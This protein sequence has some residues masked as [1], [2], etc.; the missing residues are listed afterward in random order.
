MAE[1]REK[2]DARRPAP[3]QD[4]IASFDNRRRK[5]KTVTRPPADKMARP[6]AIRGGY[7]TK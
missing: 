1:D 7:Q 6:S 2:D 5:P 3:E 4:D